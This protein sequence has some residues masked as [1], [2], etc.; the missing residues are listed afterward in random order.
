MLDLLQRLAD[1]AVSAR[2]KTRARS[3]GANFHVARDAGLK[4]LRYIEFGDGFNAGRRLRLEAID[5]Y[6]GQ[7]FSPRI[8]IGRNVIV[9]DDCHI[10]AINSV[11]IGD[12]V[13]IAS[14]VLI[15]DHSHGRGESAEADLPPV[16]RS[17]YSKGGIKIGKC[18]W[19]GEGVCILPG[20]EI[21]P[22]AVIGANS[23]V[24]KDIPAYAVAA[25]NPAKVIRI[26]PRIG[27]DEP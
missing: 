14:K 6:Y 10:A 11:D 13:L 16:A 12:N 24:T 25:G 3:T 21:G 20:V 5:R 2:A 9:Q 23:V 1:G 17:L 22:F 19:I 15:S 18:V 26:Q 27:K 8:R 7:A 4:G